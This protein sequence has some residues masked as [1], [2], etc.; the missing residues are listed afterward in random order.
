[1]KTAAEPERQ[2]VLPRMTLPVEHATPGFSAV[3][4]AF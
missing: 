3:V 4:K 1:M 2:R